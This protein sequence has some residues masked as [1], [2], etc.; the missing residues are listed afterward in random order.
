[1]DNLVDN[2]I[3]YKGEGAAVAL[4]GCASNGGWNVDVPDHGPGVSARYRSQLVSRFA[5]PGL[6]RSAEGG[7]AGLGLVLS[8][9]IVHAHGGALE[10]VE[11][12]EPGAVF[13]VRL[14]RRVAA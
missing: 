1:M 6:A 14:P 5:R 10:L 7:G 3:R 8:A 4:L 13:R 12:E 9:A 2:A 11:N